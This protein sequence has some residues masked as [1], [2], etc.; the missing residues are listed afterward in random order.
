MSDKNYGDLFRLLAG[1]NKPPSHNPLA[2][3]T[4]A[5]GV[6]PTSNVSRPSLAGLVGALSNKPK[7]PE[8]SVEH[9][10]QMIEASITK[11]L[12]VN[13]GR[14]LPTIYDLA[15]GEGRKLNAAFV[16]TDLDGY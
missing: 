12:E 2:L 6:R 9:M 7:P 15:I 1:V 5:T 3:R 14:Q 11:K 4:S 10:D 13:P 16:Y 8:L